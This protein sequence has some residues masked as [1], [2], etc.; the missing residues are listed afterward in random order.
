[1]VIKISW[2]QYKNYRPISP[3]TNTNGKEILYKLINQKHKD[4]SSWPSWV[5]YIPE[6]EGCFNYKI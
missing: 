2:G 4:T 6:M 3:T 1:L 5:K